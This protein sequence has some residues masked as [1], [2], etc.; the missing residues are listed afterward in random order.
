[1]AIKK[2]CKRRRQQQSGGAGGADHAL[3]IYG[4]MNQQQPVSNID[5]TIAMSGSSGSAHVSSMPTPSMAG[6]K[7]SK[8]KLQDEIKNQLQQLQQQGGASL[9][10]SD[11]S[12]QPASASVAKVA[13][14]TSGTGNQTGG[15]AMSLNLQKGIAK[16][17]GKMSNHDLQSLN[18][19][20]TK[21]QQQQQQGGV[22]LSEIVVPLVLLYASQRYARGKTVKKSFNS[23]RKSRRLTK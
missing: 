12:S 5:N 15:N 3:K 14:N 4:D 8:R 6:G 20:L 10:F 1:M 7:K 18:Q 23:M 21:L 13:V 22:G 9:S 2:S 17:G 19:Q 11:Y 16:V